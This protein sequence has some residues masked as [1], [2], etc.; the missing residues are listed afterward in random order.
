MTQ[1][2]RSSRQNP[3]EPKVHTKLFL[4]IS[5]IVLSSCTSVGER[6]QLSVGY[7]NVRGDNF[8]QLDQQIALHGPEI[9]GVGK[10]LAA[11]R[12]RMLPD[13]RYKSMGDGC[14]ISKAKVNV[15]AKVTLPRL[16][17]ARRANAELKRAWSNLEEYARVHEA[18]HVAIADRHAIMI[19]KALIDLPPQPTCRQLQDLARRTAGKMLTDHEAEQLNFD[20]EEKR[21]ID[22]IVKKR[23]KPS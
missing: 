7:Y 15:Q 18:V 9:E 4:I 20:A 12:I 14:S 1:A 13:V 21:R 22:A 17:Q 5:L 11:T 3:L 19:E 10:A 23:G 8:E 16:A 2:T 6:T